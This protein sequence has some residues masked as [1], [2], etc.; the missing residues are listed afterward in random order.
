MAKEEKVEGG[1]TEAAEGSVQS[2]PK[3]KRGLIKWVIL[4]IV[5]LMMGGG[6]F[7]GWKVLSKKG[8]EGQGHSP[9]SSEKE[10]KKMDAA[11][12]GIMIPLESFV[13]NL[14]DSEDIKY[15]KMTVNLEVDSAKSSEEAQARMPQ[16]RDAL[17]M[18]LTSKTSNDVKEIG[19]KLKLQDEM[20]ARVNNHLK[21]G[22]AKAVYFTE[23]VMQ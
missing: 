15:L 8:G 4:G 18:L 16:I 10:E 1:G 9:A 5:V 6:G 12:P 2:T 7:F 23:F 21:E 22:K 20:V 14:A 11:T 19:G 17:L 3:G 13:I